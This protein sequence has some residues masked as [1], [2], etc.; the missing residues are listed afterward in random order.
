MTTRRDDDRS[1]PTTQRDTLKTNFADNARPTGSQFAEWIDQSVIQG[2]DGFTITHAGATLDK[3]LN[4]NATRQPALT[5]TGQ[6]QLN[7][8]LTVTGDTEVRG[9][10]TVT[11]A[12]GLQNTLTVSQTTTLQNTLSVADHTELSSTLHVTGDTTQDGTHTNT[13]GIHTQGNLTAE[14]ATHLNGPVSVGQP[15]LDKSI[16][17]HDALMHLAHNSD[18]DQDVLKITSYA[19]DTTPLVVDAAG[20]LGLGQAEPVNRLDV[21]GSQ[22][23]GADAQKVEPLYSLG[24]QERLGVGTPAPQSRLDVRSD[25]NELALT[26]RQ[27]EVALLSLETGLDNTQAALG[28][29]G[30]TTLQGTLDVGQDTTLE[31]TL[32][33]A[34]TTSLAGQLTV[35]KDTTLEKHLTVAESTILQ[36]TLKVKGDTTLVQNA[37]IKGDTQLENTL[38][39]TGATQ[40][41]AKLTVQGDACYT[42]TVGIGTTDSQPANASLHIKETTTR[43]ALRVEHTNGKDSL[44]LTGTDLRIGAT[45]HAVNL[46]QTGDAHIKGQ[47]HTEGSLQ[48]DGTSTLADQVTAQTGLTVQ[49]D[50]QQTGHTALRIEASGATNQALEIRHDQTPHNLILATADKV[51]IQHDAPEVGLH[52][53]CETRI[54]QNA[55]IQGN[56]TVQ[57]DDQTPP[58][59]Q[60]QAGQVA[61]GKTVTTPPAAMPAADSP[62]MP[63][64]D[65]QGD[66]HINGA[67]QL[68]GDQT[69]GG[70]QHLSGNSTIRGES[71]IQGRATVTGDM[72]I[73]N[74]VEIQPEHMTL[75]THSAEPILHLNHASQAQQTTQLAAG[76]IGINVTQP[77]QAL[78]VTGDTQLTGRLEVTDTLTAEAGQITAHQPTTH[79]QTVTI[80]DHLD[81]HAGIHINQPGIAEQPVDLHLRQSG[82]DSIALRITQP[83]RNQPS[84]VVRGDRI[85]INT[86]Q[87]EQPLHVMGSTR[88]DDQLYVGGATALDDSLTVNGATRLDN[89]LEIKDQVIAEDNVTI[90]D[91]LGLTT[92]TPD[93]RIHIDNIQGQQPTSL[94]IDETAAAPTLLVRQA[95]VGLGTTDPQAT[96][97]VAGDTRVQ[98]NLQVTQDISTD[99]DLMVAGHTRLHSTLEVAHGTHLDGDLTVHSDV[100][101]SEKLRVT[102]QVILG[103]SPTDAED[104]A[105]VN[106]SA[107]LYIDNSRYKEA[108][109]ITGSSGTGLIY[110]DDKLGIGR[111][112][113]GEALD[114][115]GNS[116]ITGH[117]EVGGNAEMTGKLKVDNNAS[118]RENVTIHQNL[119]GKGNTEIEETLTVGRETHLKSDLTVDKDTTLNKSL[120][121]TGKTGLAQELYVEGKTELASNLQVQQDTRLKGDL[122]LSGTAS[123]AQDLNITGRIQAGIQTDASRAHYHL[124]GPGDDTPPFILDKKGRDPGQPLLQVN[125]NGYIGIGTATPQAALDVC[126]NLHTTQLNTSSIQADNTR[127]RQLQIGT[128]QTVVGIDADPNLGA[129]RGRDDLLATQ[130]AIKAYIHEVASPFGNSR[131][132]I[133]VCSQHQFDEQF[134]NPADATI[135]ADTTII[136]L[137]LAHQNDRIGAYQLKRSVRLESGVSIIGF[138]AQTTLM[139]KQTPEA[140]LELVGRSDNPVQHVTLDGFTYDGCNQISN[141]NGGAFYLQHAEHCNLNCHI[142][143]H[144]TA[145]NGGALYAEQEGS[146]YTASQIEARHIHHCSAHRSGGAAHGLSES[147]IHAHHCTAYQG[148]AVAYC[149]TSQVEAYHCSASSDGGAASYADLLQLLARHCQAKNGGGG[150][151]YCKDLLCT[152]QWYGNNATIGPNVYTNDDRSD[153]DHKQYYWKAD[154]LGQRLT[155]GAGEWNDYNT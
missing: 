109:H 143:N 69:I 48:V 31:K 88:L 29:S 146:H 76:S 47:A 39:V 137:P 18:I 122:T 129:D 20:N 140:R 125:A 50:A 1:L 80:Q 95:R 114:V 89:T 93:A 28:F 10:L 118:F 21:Q 55:T 116:H 38:A 144:V 72:Q 12:T 52:V 131:R 77:T 68:S 97:D 139:Q 138:N 120:R 145:L 81:V 22:Y 57:T 34:G 44:S 70:D 49:Q 124:Q 59:L 35:Q 92:H 15:V 106:P 105:S 104:A 103:V 27:N 56:L 101:I 43:S 121:V 64:L 147:V 111:E 152:G 36:D 100:H 108:L 37:T 7:D 132:T 67:V 23:I 41:D 65:V 91:N 6:T 150:A 99:Q 136:L 25:V 71:H 45:D 3:P 110:R 135:P 130:A 155:Q 32:S 112:Q 128:S 102:E 98:Q 14:Q 115:V 40:L 87:P 51:G 42:Q 154:Y 13:G 30:K 19:D 107:Q 85:G 123:L 9:E 90:A 24:V 74:W 94:R 79:E 134:N 78:E 96:L 2:D 58:G 142:K 26:V 151:Y 82:T 61:I 127:T 117:L 60:V 54:D 153:A 149:A 84:L 62:T 4:I 66:T 75:Q 113:P 33:V 83:R 73:N 8:T 5:V 63:A 16:G 119:R 46:T 133:T 53:G 126:G 17:G 11:G 148:G 141:Q 86:D